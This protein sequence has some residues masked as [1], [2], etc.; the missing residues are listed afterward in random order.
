LGLYNQAKFPIYTNNERAIL[1]GQ[2]PVFHERTNHIA[3]K[4]YYIRQLIKKRI[5]DLIHIRSKYQKADGFTKALNKIKFKSFLNQIGLIQNDL[6][7]NKKK[8]KSN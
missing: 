4:Y 2:N 7:Q 8:L 3:V 1:L 6:N 5:I